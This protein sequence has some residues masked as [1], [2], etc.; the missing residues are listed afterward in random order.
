[1]RPWARPRAGP[2]GSERRSAPGGS[3]T[4][5]QVVGADR[6]PDSASIGVDELGARV[7]LRVLLVGDVLLPRPSLAAVEVLE[8]LEGQRPEARV[9]LDDAGDPAVDDAL[10]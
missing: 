3:G 6:C 4:D 9:G 7:L 2:F 5:R 1:M 10:H 8:R